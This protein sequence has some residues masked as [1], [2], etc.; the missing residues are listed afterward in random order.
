MAPKGTEVA[1]GLVRD[2][3]FGAI[4][5]AS[6]GG[7]LVEVL[8][9]VAF[10]L[11]PFGPATARRLLGELGIA[12]VLAGVRGRPPVNWNALADALARFAVLA[13]LLGDGLAEA[14]VNP[15]IAGPHGVIAVDALIRPAS[16]TGG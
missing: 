11:P 3:Q 13:A 5:M 6:A 10:A 1:F 12:K 8:R 9:D 2:P 4:V 14:D 15:L 7:E 16:G